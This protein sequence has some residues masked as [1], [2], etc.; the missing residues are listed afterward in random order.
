MVSAGK[1]IDRAIEMTPER[2]G[3]ARSFRR[4]SRGSTPLHRKAN[5]VRAG[6]TLI[7]LLVATTLTLILMGAVVS[8]FGNLA[9]SIAESRSTLEMTDRLRT[10]S[11]MLQRD[12]AGATATMLPPQRP[13]AA[14]GYFEIIEGPI[15]TGPTMVS[16]AAIAIKTDAAGNVVPDTTVGD[17]DDI[18]MF[19]S[20][21]AERPFVGRFAGSADGLIRSDLAEVAWFVR[22]N[23]LYRRVL[24]IAPG[25]NV[26]PGGAQ[27]F[28]AGNDISVRLVGGRLLANSLTDLTKREFRFAHDFRAWPYDARGW[29]HLGLPTLRECSAPNWIAGG[30]PPVSKLSNQ[31]D[32]WNN[33]TPWASTSW[34]RETGC[35]DAYR[36]GLRVADD[37]VLTNVIRFDVKVWDPGAN[38]YVDL[39]YNTGVAIPPPG[40]NLPEPQ[41]FHWGDPRSG[42]AA[43]ANAARVYDT[44][45]THYEVEGRGAGDAMAGRAVNGFDDN[46]NGLVDDPTEAIAPPPYPAPLRGIQ[47]K[48][49]TFEPDS[50]QIRELTVVQDFLPK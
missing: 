33:P 43:S 7:E 9:N 36:N 4:P 41:F 39:G 45:S 22:G 48:I 18:L 6:F 24:L 46:D 19:T 35:L 8:L 50:R 25:A 40:S 42:L 38:D 34:E 10:V 27:G 11:T 3:E 29:G 26:P 12:L 28:Y 20:R 21:S 1:F 30:T 37:I 14:R 17:F 49:R 16:P 47:V 31:I 2:F 44:W 5:K 32:L 15:G 23:T 13:D